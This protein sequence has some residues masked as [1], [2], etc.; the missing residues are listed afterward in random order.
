MLTNPSSQQKIKF[1]KTQKY[2][3]FLS[4][5]HIP[6]YK[7]KQKKPKSVFLNKSLIP[8]IKTEK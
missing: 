4:G 5:K 8:S 7:T 6:N 2:R 3:K 1:L